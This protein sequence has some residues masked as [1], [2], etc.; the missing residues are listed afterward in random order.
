MVSGGFRRSALFG[1]VG[2]VVVAVLAAVLALT[3]DE[4]DPNPKPTLA[5]IFGVIAVFVVGLIA[6]QRADLERAAH[7]EA[8]AAS[9]PAT[10]GGRQVENPTTLAEPD[11]WAAMATA[12]IGPEALRAREASWDV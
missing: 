9:R 3:M 12:P 8:A 5:L 2:V 7:G 11:L 6:L 1:I 10:E 4:G